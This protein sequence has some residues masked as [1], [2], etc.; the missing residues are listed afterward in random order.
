MAPLQLCI[1]WR[2]KENLKISEEHLSHSWWIASNRLPPVTKEQTQQHRMMLEYVGKVVSY[3]W[4]NHS[5]TWTSIDLTI[6]GI[7]IQEFQ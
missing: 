5:K 4:S 1:F 2:K 7:D 3:N 6:A